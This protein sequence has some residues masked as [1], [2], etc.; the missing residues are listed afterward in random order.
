LEEWEKLRSADES[1]A[2]ALS[3]V[4][5]LLRDWDRVSS[6]DSQAMS[7][8]VFAG[9]A[10][11]RLERDGDEK[12]WL[13]MRALE[14]AMEKLQE[15]WGSWHVAWGEIN[16][17][18]RRHTG[19]EDPFSDE[20]PSLA[21]AGVPGWAGAMFTF[22]ATTVEGEK[23]R[24]GVAGNTYV[25]VVEFGPEVKA[26]TLHTFGASADPSSKH[27][28]D[29]APHYAEGDFKAAWL[30]LADVKENAARSYHPGP[31]RQ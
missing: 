27:H 9:E 20:K 4:V 25:A 14:K 3:E 28:F 31:V 15:D 11:R 18:Q 2:E 17:L 30:K 12:D 24:Y 22:Y 5:I 29:Q 1:R 7:L 10:K 16:R 23:R 13:T 26:K 8:F 19:G 6:V 21:I